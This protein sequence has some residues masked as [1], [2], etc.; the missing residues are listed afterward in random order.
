MTTFRELC[1]AVVLAALFFGPFF[2]YILFFLE[3][4]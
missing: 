3:P 1:E 4:S 2:I